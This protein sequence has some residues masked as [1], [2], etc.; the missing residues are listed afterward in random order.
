MSKCAIC[1]GTG[2]V[3]FYIA[4]QR[5]NASAVVPMIG[6]YPAIVALLSV[7]FLGERLSLIQ[8][9][10]IVLAVTGVMLIGAG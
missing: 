10:G 2:L 5:G 7:A 3:T 1:G 9:A 8:Y 6:I 4:L